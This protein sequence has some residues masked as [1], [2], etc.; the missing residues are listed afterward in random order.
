MYVQ[1]YTRSCLLVQGE[2]R[3]EPE[4]IALTIIVILLIIII[5][6]IIIIIVIVIIIIAV[7]I[8]KCLLNC[9]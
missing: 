3:R 2:D 6:I 7:V 9:I 8:K 5:I 1:S 4:R